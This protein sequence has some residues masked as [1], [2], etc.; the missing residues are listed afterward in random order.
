MN[1]PLSAFNPTGF[2]LCAN[3]GVTIVGYATNIGVEVEAPA[4]VTDRLRL[5]VAFSRVDAE[6]D[7]T[8][9][10]TTGGLGYPFV[11]TIRPRAVGASMRWVY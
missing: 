5:D 9:A 10:S 2:R 8:S 11:T 7:I 4:L 3:D 6:F 1:F